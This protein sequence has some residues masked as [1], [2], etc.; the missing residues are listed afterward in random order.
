MAIKFFLLLNLQG[1][2]RLAKWYDSYTQKEKNRLIKD[3]TPLI[4]SRASKLCNVIEHGDQ[5][6]VYKKYASLYFIASIDFDDN[7]L[8][9]LSTIHQF[10]EVLDKYFNGVYELHIIY[11]FHKVY[12]LVDEYLLGGELQDSSKNTIIRTVKSSDAYVE[13]ELAEGKCS[14]GTEDD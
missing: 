11:N 4:L 7:E 3:I 1:K 12:Y 2:T 14:Q 9:T 13:D 5:K 6:I 8:I 10:V